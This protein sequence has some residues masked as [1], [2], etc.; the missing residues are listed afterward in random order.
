VEAGDVVS[1]SRTK[2][3]PHTLGARSVEPPVCADSDH[4]LAILHQSAS[5]QLLFVLNVHAGRSTFMLRF[6]D[7]GIRAL[8]PE[9]SDS[10]VIPVVDRTARVELGP[11]TGLVFQAIT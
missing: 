10:P 3:L 7:S 4:G 8:K 6:A 2:D 9:L 1:L 11:H 5:R